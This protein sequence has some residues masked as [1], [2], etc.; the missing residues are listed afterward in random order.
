MIAPKSQNEGNEEGGG[1]PKSNNG[2]E[3]GQEEEEKVFNLRT[4]YEDP[5][6]VRGFLYKT[7]QSIGIGQSR[8][9]YRR[10]YIFDKLSKTLTIKDS[11]EDKKGDEVNLNEN[12]LKVDTNLNTFLKSDW[13][14]HFPGKK[15]SILNEM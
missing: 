4:T 1:E 13:L 6:V 9:F 8:L 3:G 2:D 11:P 12:V 7:A 10:Y 15:P 14:Q 5:S